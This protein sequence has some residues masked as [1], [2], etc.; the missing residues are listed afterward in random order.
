[1]PGEASRGPETV[2]N[3]C[4]CM[5]GNVCTGELEGKRVGEGEGGHLGI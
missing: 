3:L 2:L 4:V 1:M 5:W